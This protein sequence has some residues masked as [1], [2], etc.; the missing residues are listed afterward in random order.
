MKTFYYAYAWIMARPVFSKINNLIYALALRGLGVYNY[1]NSKISGEKWLIH[2]V[3]KKLGNNLVILD[4]GANVGNYTKEILSASVNAKVIYSFE[5]H[6]VTYRTLERNLALFNQAVTVNLALSNESGEMSLFDRADGD[7]TSHAS[8]SGEIF[9][10]VHHVEKNCSSVSVVTLD[11][12]CTQKNISTIDFLKIDVE[13]YEFNVLR[14]S[15]VMLSTGKIKVI[16]FEFTQLNSVV[17]VFFKDIYDILSKRYDIYRLL[18]HGLRK[19]ESYNPTMCEIFGYQ[20]YV[21][22]LRED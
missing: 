18:P 14:G 8:L 12:F 3:V 11:G 16:Q 20:N 5:P 1:N 10:E 6:P 4:V 2:N 9:L 13:G 17:G 15:N 22:I 19:I 7:G 21:A